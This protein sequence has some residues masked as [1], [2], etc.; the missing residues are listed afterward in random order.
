MVGDNISLRPESRLV[1][2][3]I[4]P[5][6]Q[7][8]CR[9][10][11]KKEVICLSIYHVTVG[12][13]SDLAHVSLFYIAASGWLEIDN[14]LHAYNSNLFILGFYEIGPLHCLDHQGGGIIRA[15][16]VS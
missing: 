9:P 16:S 3:I 10:G 13:R 12:D 6:R 1:G 2:F 4:L 15:S 14:F 7:K 11:T 5:G 8:K